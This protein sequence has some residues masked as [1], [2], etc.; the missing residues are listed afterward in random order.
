MFFT[1]WHEM[2]AMILTKSFGQCQKE[3]INKSEQFWTIDSDN[4]HELQY[5]FPQRILWNLIPV[6]VLFHPQV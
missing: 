4:F 3:P 1:P 2:N 5:F 6:L